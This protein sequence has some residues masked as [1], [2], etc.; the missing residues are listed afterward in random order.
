MVGGSQGC[1]IGVSLPVAGLDGTPA[2]EFACKPHWGYEAA[3]MG[4]DLILGYPF[5]KKV[6]PGSGLPLCF[7]EERTNPH[8]VLFALDQHDFE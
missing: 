2:Q 3:V 1:V 5:L 4:C 8:I 6:P 7:T